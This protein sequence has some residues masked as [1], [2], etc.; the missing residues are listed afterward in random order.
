MIFNITLLLLAFL[1]F[2]T[3]PKIPL[4]KFCKN[5]Q[6][7]RTQQLEIPRET[8]QQFIS[9][10]LREIDQIIITLIT[11]QQFIRDR[12][13]EIDETS[14]GNPAPTYSDDELIDIIQT[15]NRVLDSNHFRI[16]HRNLIDLY[17]SRDENNNRRY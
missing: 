16:A 11:D 13:R 8:N 9:R 4:S 12:L 5:P 3:L 6:S 1:L 7:T 15:Y 10:R 14:L 17:Y 2:H